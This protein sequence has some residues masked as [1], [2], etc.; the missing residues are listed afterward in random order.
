V[1]VTRIKV[2]TGFQYLW[3]KRGP[4]DVLGGSSISGTTLDDVASRS[5]VESAIS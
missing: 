3:D 4:T 5:T 2:L 1:S